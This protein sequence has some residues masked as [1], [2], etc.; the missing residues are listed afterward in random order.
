VKGQFV[1]AELSQPHPTPL[2]HVSNASLSFL[3]LLCVLYIRFYFFKINGC[4]LLA[5]GRGRRYFGQWKGGLRHGRGAYQWAVDGRIYRGEWKNGQAHGVGLMTCP[6]RPDTTGL[7][8][9]S[10]MVAPAASSA[11]NPAAAAS[12]AARGGAGGGARGATAAKAGFGIL[13][14]GADLKEAR[15]EAA[16]TREVRLV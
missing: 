13:L 11:T 12:N 4:G 14:P 6:R 3:F 1:L 16:K 2:K 8:D 7:L 10:D 5:L 15:K 9:A